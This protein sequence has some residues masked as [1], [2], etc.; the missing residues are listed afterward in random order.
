M[1]K[2]LLLISFFILSFLF[3][4]KAQVQI[5][6]KMEVLTT[7]AGLPTREVKQMIQDSQGFMWFGTT[8]GII[9][10]DGYRYKVYNSKAGNSLHIPAERVT[11]SMIF[12]DSN[13]LWYVADNQLYELNVYTNKV[14]NLSD[15]YQLEGA[16]WALHQAEDKSVS[17]VTD[18]ALLQKQL[19]QVFDGEKFR[20][21]AEEPRGVREFTELTSN[22]DGTIWWSTFLGGTKQYNAE[23]D[24]LTQVKP[25][26]FQWFGDPMFTAVSFFD[27]RG[28]HYVLPREPKGVFELVGQD[29]FN[30]LIE[31]PEMVNL[32]I[33]DP[34]N[35]LWFAGRD[36]LVLFQDGN[37]QS[38]TKRMHKLLDYSQINDLFIDRNGLLWVAT[39]GG[40][41]KIQI[42]TQP[43]K[44]IF[45]S[46]TK[47]WGN[48][49]RSI[50]STPNGR[51]FAMNESQKSLYVQMPDGREQKFSVYGITD[52]PDPLASARQFVLSED[53]QFAY[54]VNHTLLKI[55]LNSG[56]MVQYPEAETFLN[57]TNANPLLRLNDG[58]LLLG[59]SLATLAIFD[60]E[61]EQFEQ[62]FKQEQNEALENIRVML[63]SHKSGEVWLGTLNSG[64]AKISLS[65][66]LLGRFTTNT[67]PAL[68]KNKVNALYEDKEGG[69]WVGTFGGGINYLSSGANEFRVLDR[70]S[71]LADEN[72]VAMLPDKNGFLWIAT[73]KGLCSFELSTGKVR[74]YFT[75]DGLSHN[76][77]NVFSHY[78]S[79]DGA[80]HFGGMNGLNKFYPDEILAAKEAP[81]LELV[82]VNVNDGSG[83]REVL[84]DLGEELLNIRPKDLYFNVNWSLP[85]YFTNEQNSYFTK[86]EGYEDD[87]IYQGVSPFI[88]YN[89]LPPGDYVLRVK[90][91]DARGNT[92]ERELAI[93]LHVG[94]V[95]YK[96]W[97]FIVL[98]IFLIAL[99][100]YAF[101]NLRLR[102]YKRMER[103]RNK[104]SSDLH[105]DVGSLL[106]GL[107]MQAELLALQAQPEDQKSL[108]K[109]GAL[110]R[111]AVS[112]MRDLVWS[113]DAR[114]EQLGDLIERMRELAEE[115]LLSQD[116]TFNIDCNSVH[117]DRKLP[118]QTK[119][120]LFLIFKEA[121]NNMLKH[122]DATHLEVVVRNTVKGAELSIADNGTI[123]A[124]A[125]GAGLGLSNMAYRVEQMKGAINFNTG[126]G[127]GI[128]INLPFNL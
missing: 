8:Q 18:D 126:K 11:G 119:Q 96:T 83:D 73:Y 27:S 103:L 15:Q 9:R 104:I 112:Q 7:E 93:P 82:N 46:D 106:S 55:D 38:F 41:V 63:E 53:E 31:L 17:I 2:R 23:G 49:M 47:G 70:S 54:T 102:Q 26:S 52:R 124:K 62:L 95:F 108:A 39:D 98:V 118:P 16:V 127:F 74:N 12:R 117:L 37:S 67:Q 80:L 40:I 122:S 87:W 10:Y 14:R 25:G 76:E 33:E 51:L 107:S 45:A 44:Q 105:D 43:F 99:L 1:T 77:F 36:Q 100:I 65:G 97:W 48:A 29:Q 84:L 101:F 85:S 75:G 71:G 5:A 32:A 6:P 61:T 30:Q 59:H 90:G 128:N 81:P 19:L 115:Q 110:S 57:V 50:F 20:T 72:I 86:L 116:I 92:S 68:N 58:R 88:R 22:A 42:A 121:V 78:R 60:P 111:K 24:L 94:Q 34:M 114:K 120:H 21:I 56:R 28:K 123:S 13:L 79:A 69:L 64:V 3:A 91:V 89:K 109:I 4:G 113:I 35:R 66:E 125:Q